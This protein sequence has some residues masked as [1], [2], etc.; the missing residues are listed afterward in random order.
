VFHAAAYKHVTMAE[1]AACAAA[2]V[3][4]LGTKAVLDAACDLCARFVLISSDKAA[5]PRS[6]MGATKRVAELLTTSRGGEDAAPVAVRFGNV[7]A[8]SGSFVEIMLERVRQGRSLLITD[9]DATRYFMT[10]TEAASLVMKATTLSRGGETFWL[11]MD[12][13][14]RIGDLADRLLAVAA[15]KG[16]PRVP[17]EVIGMRPGEKRIEQ[18]TTQGLAIRRTDYPRIWVAREPAIAEDALDGHLRQLRRG[19]AHDDAI[20]VLRVLEASVAEFEA[21]GQAWAVARS[22]HLYRSSRTPR[23]AR[24]A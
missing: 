12:E 19:V 6:V 14:V 13:P 16:W 2:N 18:L 22:E 8:S 3:N 4:V 17:V 5:K 1:R 11:D 15:T 23:V 7:L 9:P 10:V 24:T 20:G 21:S